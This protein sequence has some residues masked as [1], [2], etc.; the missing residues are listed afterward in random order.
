MQNDCFSYGT[1]SKQYPDFQLPSGNMQPIGYLCQQYELRLTRPIQVHDKWA[2]H[3]PTVYRQYVLNKPEKTEIKPEDDPHCL[4]II[5]HYRSLIPM[6][7][8]HR[9]PIFKLTAAN[10][11][12]GS[13]ALAARRAEQ[14]FK[15]LAQVIAN[16]IGF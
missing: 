8:Q 16:Q 4:A 12:V 6:G 13:H 1:N 3:I 11:A 7:Q 9:T 10:G 14:D 15:Q 2:N 5:K